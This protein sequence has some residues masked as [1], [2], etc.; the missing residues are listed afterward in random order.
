M[1]RITKDIYFSK[2][3]EQQL[4]AFC[5][6]PFQVPSSFPRGRDGSPL[7]YELSL[8]R[9]DTSYASLDRVGR[10]AKRGYLCPNCLQSFK[11]F[12]VRQGADPVEFD[13]NL[14]VR[15]LNSQ[16]GN[17]DICRNYYT[18]NCRGTSIDYSC[19]FRAIAPYS[20]ATIPFYK[21]EAE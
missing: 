8:T 12:A 2:E 9:L 3:T 1:R 7:I 21:G 4:C 11:D 18:G 19:N 6:K 17:C 10:I 13:S 15:D 5:K 16:K 14:G 20:W